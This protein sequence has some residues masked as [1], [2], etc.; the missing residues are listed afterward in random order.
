[1][2]HKPILDRQINIHD[3]RNSY[4]YKKDLVEFCRLENLDKRGGKTALASRIETY[5]TTGQ[6]ETHQPEYQTTSRFNWNLAPLS[7][8]TI[9]TDNY[10]NT[11]NV[12]SFFQQKTARKFKFHVR[13]M[14]WMKSA[15]GKTL[16]EAFEKWKEMEAERRSDT[17][18][19]EIA[20]QFEYNTFI[21]DFMKDNRNST[22][23]EA[24]RCWKIKKSEP[25]NHT[26]SGKDQR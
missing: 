19:R 15:Q 10:R 11:E 12:R 24:I 23:A 2:E 21:R 4:W 14:N 25:G 17:S 22:L 20:P 8:N 16:G 18:P 5:L 7:D 1:M 6:K 3:F 9:I 13:F 26:Y